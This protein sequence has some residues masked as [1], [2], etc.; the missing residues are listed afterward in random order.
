MA[1]AGRNGPKSVIIAQRHNGM[2]W[3]NIY[4]STV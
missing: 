4:W 2:K 3:C 1:K